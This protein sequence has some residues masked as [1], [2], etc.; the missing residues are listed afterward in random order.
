MK[1]NA[2]F[3][4]VVILTMVAANLACNVPFLGEEEQPTQAPVST[5][6]VT[7]AS[8]LPGATQPKPTETP[9]PTAKAAN[10]L[11]LPL[12]QGLASLDS[13]RLTIRAGASGSDTLEKSDMVILM[14]YNAKTKSTHWKMTSTNVS[15]DEP[16]PQVSTSEYYKVGS[17]SCSLSSSSS[18]TKTPTAKIEDSDLVAQDLANSLSYLVDYNLYAENPVFVAEETLNGVVTNHF[19]FKVTQLGKDSGAVVKQNSGEYWVAK[20][21]QYL[22]KYTVLLEMDSDKSGT[23]TVRTELNLELTLINKTVEIA[24]PPNCTTK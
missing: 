14:E 11:P 24:F 1:R 3:F 2:L 4:W 5:S 17:K 19:K 22:V 15:E 20:D 21:G 8:P 6:A 23:K 10:P 18:S 7:K 12:R 13:Y 9:K 16:K